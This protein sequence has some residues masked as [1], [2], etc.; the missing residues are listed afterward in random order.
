MSSSGEVA[1]HQP[2]QVEL[3]VDLRVRDAE[4]ATLAERDRG[5]QPI[6]TQPADLDLRAEIGARDSA[7]RL[8]QP[9]LGQGSPGEVRRLRDDHGD[10]RG[11]QAEAQERTQPH[12]VFGPQV[13]AVGF[14]AATPTTRVMN[15]GIAATL[16]R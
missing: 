14:G 12:P 9:A 10:Q 1:A 11:A 6:A 8:A 3:D 15:N 16:R 13:R 4:R 5:R 7:Q 2:P